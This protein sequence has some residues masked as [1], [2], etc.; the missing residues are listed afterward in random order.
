MKKGKS[1]R[2]CLPRSMSPSIDMHKALE[3]NAVAAILAANDA[4]QKLKE[5]QMTSRQR[6]KGENF[7]PVSLARILDLMGNEFVMDALHAYFIVNGMKVVVVERE[8]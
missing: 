1:N 8:I 3:N 6:K 7:R 5:S 4:Y 2:R